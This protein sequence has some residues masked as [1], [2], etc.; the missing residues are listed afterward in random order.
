MNCSHE[1]TR[2]LLVRASEC[3]FIVVTVEGRS[4][5]AV[6]EGWCTDCG[7]MLVSGYNGVK[8]WVKP[9]GVGV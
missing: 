8:H 6:A 9:R 2:K 5:P 7:A 1:N 4:L 3:A